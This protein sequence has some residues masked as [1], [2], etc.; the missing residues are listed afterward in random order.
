MYVISSHDEHTIKPK[1]DEFPQ[2]D[3]E[4]SLDKK[5]KMKMRKINTFLQQINDSSFL[6]DNEIEPS[7]QITENKNWEDRKEWKDMCLFST[8]GL[9]FKNM[10][11]FVKKYETKL[12]KKEWPGV[13]EDHVLYN[14]DVHNDKFFKNIELDIITVNFRIDFNFCGNS[15]NLRAAQRIFTV[16]GTISANTKYGATLKISKSNLLQLFFGGD[17]LEVESFYN[18]IILDMV[19]ELRQIFKLKCNKF[20][21]KMFNSGSN[22][23]EI[24][25]V[26]DSIFIR[27]LPSQAMQPALNIERLKNLHISNEQNKSDNKD[28]FSDECIT[29]YVTWERELE[30]YLTK[31]D[32]EESLKVYSDKNLTPEDVL[33]VNFYITTPVQAVF[34]KEKGKRDDL[35]EY[36]LH[37]RLTKYDSY[38]QFDTKNEDYV[39]QNILDLR[40][41][42][43]SGNLTEK[44]ST[45]RR[46][47]FIEIM[48][49]RSENDNSYF[50]IT[51]NSLNLFLTDAL[52][53]VTRNMMKK[54]HRFRDSKNISLEN[55]EI[56]DIEWKSLLFR[57]YFQM[58]QLKVSNSFPYSVLSFDILRYSIY[59][60]Y[61]P[62]SEDY[63]NKTKSMISL[64]IHSLISHTNFRNVF[65]SCINDRYLRSSSN[66]MNV[67]IQNVQN[68]DLDNGEF[69]K[70]DDVDTNGEGDGEVLLKEEE[71]RA[72]FKTI[73]D[74]NM[75]IFDMEL[76]LEDIEMVSKLP[77]NN[78][79]GWK[80]LEILDMFI[81]EVKKDENDDKYFN[82][83][84]DE[85][86]YIKNMT[87]SGIEK[88]FEIIRKVNEYSASH[89]SDYMMYHGGMNEVFKTARMITTL[90]Y[91]IETIFRCY[92][93]DLSFLVYFIMF[94][95]YDEKRNSV[96]FDTSKSWHKLKKRPKIEYSKTHM[97]KMK[98]GFDII[99]EKNIEI[100]KEQS[101]EEF[102]F[103]RLITF[104]ISLQSIFTG[105]INNEL[106]DYLHVKFSAFIGDD[107]S[108]FNDSMH[109]LCKDEKQKIDVEFE[110]WKNDPQH[111]FIVR[112]FLDTPVMAN[113]YQADLF[114]YYAYKLKMPNSNNASAQTFSSNIVLWNDVWTDR[115]NLVYG[116]QNT[117]TKLHVNEEKIKSEIMYREHFKRLDEN[118][119][120]FMNNLCFYT[121]VHAEFSNFK[122]LLKPSIHFVELS[123]SNF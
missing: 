52:E 76:E 101:D 58:I 79:P 14:I 64:L 78:V 102:H 47:N 103:Y 28:L 74:I 105:E 111:G 77:S 8:D 38:E 20:S 120:T 56:S 39:K 73:Q 80:W 67:E 15:S 89:W 121:N 41:F 24:I 59:N 13:S 90:T 85:A 99:F 108:T 43:D 114:Y 113:H 93:M 57:F 6:I 122:P 37:M 117:N 31:H 34:F 87:Q 92:E 18:N 50:L 96:F 49:K 72:E 97:K 12:K 75:K 86:K 36:P 71:D 54:I 83:K 53:I 51:R 65:Y 104:C 26:S 109:A 25:Q 81:L 66:F 7:N 29:K 112:H 27:K 84:T 19:E 3:K 1:G 40:T 44:D 106:V 10:L 30:I 70:D 42:T 62:N 23:K 88:L 45:E 61:A 55:N 100:Q 33:M 116:V 119:E 22:D 9:L 48:H 63:P 69:K 4:P 46:S 95:G 115:M 82:F 118:G 2:L 5:D 21:E 11:S 94:P 35:V 107:K 32:F 91:Y 60:V 123:K 68:N 17:Y 16:N 110:V 98:E